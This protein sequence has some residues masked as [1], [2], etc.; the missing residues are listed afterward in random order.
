MD[1]SDDNS[2]SNIEQIFR[3][4]HKMLC[5]VAYAMVKDR[6]TAEDI[7]QDVFLKLWHKRNELIIDSNLKGYLYRAVSNSCLNYLQSYHKKNV[8]LKEEFKDSEVG[9]VVMK[10]TIDAEQLE[11]V[12]NKAIDNLPP[13]CKAIFIL[14]RYEGLKQQQIADTLN[15]SL[16]TVENQMSI[17]LAKL[18]EELG[19]YLKRSYILIVIFIQ[20]LLGVIF[21]GLV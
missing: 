14:S 4:H 13:R 21:V 7:V 5:N 18:R 9:F 11:G 15:L 20:S 1:D 8:K 12:I 17:A 3:A 19:P 16:K 6:S 10:E 2:L